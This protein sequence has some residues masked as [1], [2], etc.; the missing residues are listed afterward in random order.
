MQNPAMSRRA[1]AEVL[2]DIT[3]DGV[4]YHLDKLKEEGKVKR[5]GGA[6]GK[7]RVL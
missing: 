6:R 7:W 1:L 4:K 5:I 2:G 3:E